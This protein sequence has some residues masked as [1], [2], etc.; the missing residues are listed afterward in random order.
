MGACTAFKSE[1]H[2]RA[3]AV[4]PPPAAY[5]I[6]ACLFDTVA[7]ADEEFRTWR[8]IEACQFV[9]LVGDV[10]PARQHR[11]VACELVGGVQVQQA[12]TTQ[13]VFVGG[14]VKT[15]V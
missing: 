14:I 13:D 15:L 9:V 4:L 3:M 8:C 1:L 7:H 6:T 11:P 5:L 12:I 2:L 10:V